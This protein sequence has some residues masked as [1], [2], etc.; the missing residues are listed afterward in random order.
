MIGFQTG[1]GTGGREGLKPRSRWFAV[2]K[3][4]ALA[5][6]EVT[7]EL[8][9][10]HVWSWGWAEWNEK[11]T[12]PDKTYAACV[13]LW[14]RDASLCDAPGVLG[15]E[16]DPDLRAGQLNLPAGV[17]CT[18]GSTAIREASISSLATLTDDRELALTA[19]VLRAVERERARVSTSEALALERR[20]VAARFGG[21]QAAYRSALGEARV[22]LPVARDIA[23]DELRANE[24]QSRLAVPA[25]STKDVARFRE[26][27]AP[28]LAREI[29]VSP[30]PSWLPGGSGVALATSAPAAVFRVPTGRSATIRTAEGRFTVVAREDTTA[31]GAVSGGAA[32]AAAARELRAE[33]RAEAYSGWSIRMQKAAGSRLVCARDE[34]PEPGAVRLSAFVP[35]LSLHEAEADRWVSARRSA[36]T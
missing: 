29:D 18:Y 22:S 36:Q 11:S 12:D 21:N 3:W 7:R 9:L 27:Y 17:R 20:V 14:T 2:A 31:L 25:P 19:L 15:D 28:V 32:S 23:A 4:Q 5:A 16:F 1:P 10:A 30:A 35:F 24:I 33:M 6:R 34:L 13:W 26:T 8:R